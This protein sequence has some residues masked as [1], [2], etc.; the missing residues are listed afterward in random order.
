DLPRIV[1]PTLVIG[2]RD[3][4]VTPAYFS[5]ELGRLIP[6]AKVVILPAGGHFFPITRAEEFRRL[7]LDFLQQE[8]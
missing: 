2:A 6:N 4:A 5:E 1:A 8:T 3:D 7:V